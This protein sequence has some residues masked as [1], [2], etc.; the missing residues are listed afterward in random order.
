MKDSV[1]KQKL[2]NYV[3]T[4]EVV[5]QPTNHLLE[6]SHPEEDAFCFELSKLVL[7]SNII[8][9]ESFE[10]LVNDYEELVT[11]SVEESDVLVRVVTNV[12]TNVDYDILLNIP[13]VE[14]HLVS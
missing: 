12:E 1:N 14:F 10:K 5:F 7:N 4:H 6:V 9:V 2:A 3:L 8:K 13:K 11:W